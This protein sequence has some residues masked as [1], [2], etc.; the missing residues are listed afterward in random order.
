MANQTESTLQLCVQA[1]PPDKPLPLSFISGYYGVFAYFKNWINKLEI[2]LFITVSMPNRK[3]HIQAWY[4]FDVF[5][6]KSK[7]IDPRK[8][9][10]KP[11]GF[12][13]L[14][15]SSLF[16]FVKEESVDGFH[17]GFW[18]HSLVDR[19]ANTGIRMARVHAPSIPEIYFQAFWNCYIFGAL[20]RT[21][22]SF[23]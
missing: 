4:F 21:S 3:R 9:A 15:L 7:Q 19:S 11:Q 1:K 10:E 23:F 22:S 8:A 16:L 6:K 5:G 18:P 20:V 13:I 14:W 2:I 12:S 17:A